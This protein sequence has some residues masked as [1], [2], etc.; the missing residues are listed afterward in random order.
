MSSGSVGEVATQRLGDR[1]LPDLTR[2]GVGEGDVADG[3]QFQIAWVENLDRQ[4][5]VMG[6]DGAQRALPVDRTQE[7]ADHDRQS[8]TPLRSAQRFES[9]FQVAPHA[10]FRATGGG[11]R[12]QQTQVVGTPGVGGYADDLVAGTHH[13][14]VA[15]A[16]TGGEMHDGRRR[17][18]RELTF[19]VGDGAEVEAR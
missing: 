17:G 5:L 11:D 16:T 13:R 9:C 4:Q 3:W 8:A 7:V 2:L 19:G 12:L 15:I 14:A 6:A 1:D 10:G 18:H